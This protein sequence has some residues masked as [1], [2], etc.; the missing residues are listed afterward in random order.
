MALYILP[1]RGR[2]KNSTELD[3]LYTKLDRRQRFDRRD[4]DY[5]SLTSFI[6][7]DQGM[8][9]QVQSYQKHC[10]VIPR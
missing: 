3:V 5:F 4:V 8:T 6:L 1:R 2:V 10:F 9:T 7:C